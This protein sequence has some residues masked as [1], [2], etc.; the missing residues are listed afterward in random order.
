MYELLKALL[1]FH[2]SFFFAIAIIIAAA[3]CAASTACANENNIF[4]WEIVFG[5]QQ[6]QQTKKIVFIPALFHLLLPNIQIYFG[7]SKEAS[8]TNSYIYM[9]DK[10][11]YCEIMIIALWLQ[12][13]KIFQ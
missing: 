3:A 4:G 8:H 10:Y 11:L 13:V 1:K 6:W 9:W 2:K 7:S 12:R 5:S